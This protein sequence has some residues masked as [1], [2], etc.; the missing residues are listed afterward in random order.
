MSAGWVLNRFIY[1][2]GKCNITSKCR[3]VVIDV[4]TF[5]E[6]SFSSLKT[7]T[8]SSQSFC[9]LHGS[10]FPLFHMAKSSSP[11]KLCL[12]LFLSWFLINLWGKLDVICDEDFLV[13]DSDTI[14]TLRKSTSK[15]F[16]AS[17]NFSFSHFIFS[18]SQGIYWA[19]D[20]ETATRE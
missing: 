1:P 14:L 12:K 4:V 15:Y 3:A 13:W 8:T 5:P 10:I 9:W 20:W 7:N 19:Y 16:R 18:C 2:K 11:L 6:G 17:L